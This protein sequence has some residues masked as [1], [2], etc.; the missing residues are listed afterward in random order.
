[1]PLTAD[2]GRSYH[3]GSA[4]HFP[5]AHSDKPVNSTDPKTPTPGALAHDVFNIVTVLFG[6]QDTLESIPPSDPRIARCRADLEVVVERLKKVGGDL[7]SMT[8]PKP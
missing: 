4:V 3:R 8:P 5:I 1:M 6:V 7:V 2:R